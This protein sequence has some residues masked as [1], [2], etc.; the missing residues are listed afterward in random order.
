MPLLFLRL[1]L[2]SG[3]KVS[4]TYR[5]LK[6]CA[7]IWAYGIKVAHDGIGDQPVI[8]QW[9]IQQPAP[10]ICG[11]REWSRV[12]QYCQATTWRSSRT[13]VLAAPSATTRIRPGHVV[14]VFTHE[15]QKAGTVANGDRHW[16]ELCAQRV[17]SPRRGTPPASMIRALGDP[18]RRE[19]SL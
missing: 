12:R 7:D 2:P 14:H 17:R 5:A 11:G 16:D 1:A 18:A 9:V 8:Q 4:W 10:R 13:N 6:G 3:S 19:G 15:G